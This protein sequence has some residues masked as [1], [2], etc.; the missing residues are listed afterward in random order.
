MTTL[1]LSA[2]IALGTIAG[3]VTFVWKRYWSKEAKI[4]SLLGELDDIRKQMRGALR[5][6]N[7]NR[8]DFLRDIRSG[9]LDTLSN[10]RK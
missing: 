6:G 5:A 2:I 8:Y 4:R 9:L 3:L 10:L 7:N 1:I